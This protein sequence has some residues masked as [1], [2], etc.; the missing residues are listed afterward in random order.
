V[1]ECFT[2]ANRL[3]TSNRD[4]LDH[5]ATALLEHDSLDEKEILE[6]TGLIAPVVS[7]DART[8]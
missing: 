6:V 7:T 2:E 3:L 5:L 4:R 1:E 8:A